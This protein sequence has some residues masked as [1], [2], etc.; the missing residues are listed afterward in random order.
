VFLI[1]D[2]NGSDAA[3]DDASLIFVLYGGLHNVLKPKKTVE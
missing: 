3:G 2:S 1:K